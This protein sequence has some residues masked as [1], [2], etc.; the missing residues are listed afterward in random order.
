MRP[1]WLTEVEGSQSSV[2]LAPVTG[3]MCYRRASLPPLP[4]VPKLFF[5]ESPSM[6]QCGVLTCQGITLVSLDGD[7]PLGPGIFNV[8]YAVW[9]TT[10]NFRRKGLPRMQS[11]PMLKLATSNISTP[12]RLLSPIPRNNSRSMRPMGA[13]DNPWMTP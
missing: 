2:A 10:I 1:S 8:A 7:H 4:P 5:I 6:H 11:Y 12:L 3:M 9:M 13:D